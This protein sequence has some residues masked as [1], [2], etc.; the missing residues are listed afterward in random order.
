VGGQAGGVGGLGGGPQM[1]IEDV[2]FFKEIFGKL[3]NITIVNTI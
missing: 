2:A 3:M 1:A